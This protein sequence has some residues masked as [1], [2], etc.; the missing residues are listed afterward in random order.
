AAFENAPRL[1][2]AERGLGLVALSDGDYARA[3]ELLTM[4]LGS[5]APGL[6]PHFELGLALFG[7]GD[8][9]GAL[10]EW[11]RSGAAPYLVRTSEQV[12]DN[13]RREQLLQLALSVDPDESEA[14]LSLAR[15]YLAESRWREARQTLAS[16]PEP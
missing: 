13:D 8:Q 6:R 3:A 12:V 16:R 10:A 14:R 15:L 11:T 9:P 7:L 1:W 5:G 4:A 2:A